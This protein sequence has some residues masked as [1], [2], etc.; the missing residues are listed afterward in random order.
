MQ[1]IFS[2]IVT[3]TAWV[4]TDQR[5]FAVSRSLSDTRRGAIRWA[6]EHRPTWKNLYR[7]GWRCRRCSLVTR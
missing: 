7:L 2:G 4:L 1:M 6:T 5:G 3:G